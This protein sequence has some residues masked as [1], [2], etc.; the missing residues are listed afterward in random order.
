[1]SKAACLVSFLLASTWPAPTPVAIR[2]EPQVMTKVHSLIDENDAR[3]IAWRNGI[4]HI[5]EI[6]FHG[7][8]WEIAGR[9]REN[10]ELAID[11]DA[12]KGAVLR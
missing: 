7:D 6:A 9:D 10:L 11:V 8:R 1:M 3:R 12:K 5:E 2:T 4:V